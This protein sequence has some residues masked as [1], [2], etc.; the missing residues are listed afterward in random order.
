MFKLALRGVRN[1]VGRYVAT[2]V[3]ILTGVAFFTATGFLSDRVIN[4]LEGD[5]DRQYGSVEAAIVVDDADA[6]G[7]NF[8]DDL[9]IGGDVADQIAA[10]PEVAAIGGDLTGGV[11]FL[12]ATAR[13][14]RTERSVACGSRTRPSTRS[15]STTGTRR[16]RLA[17]SPSTVGWPTTRISRSATTSSC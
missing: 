1:N 16:P 11:A 17:R 15:T 3:A 10:L 5:A 13:P 8:A 7:S 12:G 14:R 2:L 9:R 6:Q 4:A